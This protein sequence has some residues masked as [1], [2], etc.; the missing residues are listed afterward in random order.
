MFNPSFKVRKERTNAV[1]NNPAFRRVLRVPGRDIR[2]RAVVHQLL[3]YLPIL[4]KYAP[5]CPGQFWMPFC[6]LGE[7]SLTRMVTSVAREQR[8]LF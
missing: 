4:P 3:V 5:L 6:N 2:L 1:A 7:A 8:L